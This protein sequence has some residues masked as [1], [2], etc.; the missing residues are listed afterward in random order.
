MKRTPFLLL[1]AL[2]VISTSCDQ[3][4]VGDV[5]VTYQ[6]GIPTYGDMTAIRNTPILGSVQNI[7]N[8]GKI[9][10]SPEYLFIGEEGKGVHVLDNSN[11][12]N[13]LNVAFIN[14]PGNREYFLTNNTLFAES[15]YDMLKIDVSNP[16]QPQLISRLEGGVAEEL[17]NSNGESLL[18]F[19][20]EQV[21][22]KISRDDNIFDLV[23]GTTNTTVFFDF[24]NNLIPTSAVPASFS[25]NSANN[26]GSVN[27]V[28]E[29]DGFI[30]M[31]SRTNLLV[32]DNRTSFD[33]VSHQSIG[34]DMETV[35]PIG[36][37]L[38]VGSR[39]SVEI[40]DISDPTNPQWET[41]FW[42]ATSCDPVYPVSEELAYVTLRTGDFA[43]CPGDQNALV[44]LDISGFNL[45]QSIQEIPMESPFG[46]TKIGTKLYVGEGANGLKIFDASNERFLV[47]EKSETG[48]SAYDVLQH[49]TRTDIILIAGPDGLGQYQV[50]DSFDLL[51]N[52]AF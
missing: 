20:F 24:Q 33:K 22:E 7:E 14:I 37:R 1:L 44:V 43:E 50:Q 35:Y 36:D 19:E 34:W 38:F 18:S 52:V 6:K 11:P 31:V 32:F 48:L 10:V 8:A 39:N 4:L 46:L 40:L 51:S 28:V 49:P 2:T 12:E 21:T 16:L 23:W 29:K 42:H 41:S 26:I 5:T 27:R 25:G 47:L 30:Y 3:D 17:V 45:A 13:P 9:F 15:Y